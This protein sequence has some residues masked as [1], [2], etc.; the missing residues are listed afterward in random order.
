[1]SRWLPAAI[2]GALAGCTLIIGEI[3]LPDESIDAAAVAGAWYVYGL[4]GTRPVE[5]RIEIAEDGRITVDENTTQAARNGE[6]WRFALKPLTGPLTGRID[7]EAG[8]GLMVERGADE[9]ETF[10]VL[11]REPAERAT[12][13][14][15]RTVQLGLSE[16]GTPLAEFGGL[17]VDGGV[18]VQ[19]ARLTLTEQVHPART[20]TVSPLSGEAP[21]W[22]VNLGEEADGDWLLSPLAGGDGALGVH[23]SANGV[24]RGPF[25]LWR[26]PVTATLPERA[27]ACAGL[28]IEDGAAVSRSRLA[29]LS[30]ERVTWSDGREGRSTVVDGV[31]VLEGDGSFF[32]D[33]GTMVLPDTGGRLFALLPL[34]PDPAGEDPPDRRWGVA[35][36]IGA[37]P[38]DEPEVDDAGA[39]DA[40]VSDAAP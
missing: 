5:G 4:A 29:R 9:P 11:V 20:V 25:V 30:A 31:P 17:M 22:V 39:A 35:L 18:Y 12:L 26:E 33:V 34:V 21:R 2:A 14:G 6:A 7:A 38:A 10:V 15:G 16:A 13:R 8:I 1:M 27:L 36:C 32:D 40:G 37:D 23:R 19:S 28:T 3:P 24:A